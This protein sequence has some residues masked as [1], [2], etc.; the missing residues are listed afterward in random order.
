MGTRLAGKMRT[1]LLHMLFLASVLLAT[2]ALTQP[3]ATPNHDTALNH[4][5][6]ML[7]TNG[8]TQAASCRGPGYVSAPAPPRS[9]AAN[10][11]EGGVIGTQDAGVKPQATPQDSPG[12]SGSSGCATAG[13]VGPCRGSSGGPMGPPGGQMARLLKLAGRAVGGALA[14]PLA[15]AAAWWSACAGAVAA[16]VFWHIW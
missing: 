6:P 9:T 3:S 4:E 13:T 2:T 1:L 12:H 11:H 10:S 5:P 8:F 16:L 14:K 7:P 15:P